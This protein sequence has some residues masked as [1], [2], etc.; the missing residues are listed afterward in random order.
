M[1]KTCTHHSD[2]LTLIQRILDREA[3]PEE[4]ANFLVNKDQCLPCQEG[5]EL[6]QSM[7]KAIKSNCKS[8]CPQDLFVRIKSKL[9]VV[10][11]LISI[12]IPLFC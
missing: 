5:Y 11:I 9:F 2:C 12:L 1:K 4:E 6:E 8:K 7:R 3:T 10:L